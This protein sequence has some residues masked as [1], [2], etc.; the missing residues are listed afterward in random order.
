VVAL[1]G[2]GLS[3]L[4]TRINP[5]SAHFYLPTK[6]SW[7][8]VLAVFLASFVLFGAVYSFY[9]SHFAPVLPRV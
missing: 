5:L 3:F 7:S 8:A 2:A 6:P 9:L 1:L 4:S